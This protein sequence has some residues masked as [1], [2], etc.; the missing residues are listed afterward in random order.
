MKQVMYA[1]EIDNGTWTSYVDF[2]NS[3]V[4]DYLC[5]SP[6]KDMVECELKDWKQHIFQD[7]SIKAYLVEE[8]FH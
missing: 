5:L 8:D 6:D 3:Q 7:M 4:T 2:S 1:L